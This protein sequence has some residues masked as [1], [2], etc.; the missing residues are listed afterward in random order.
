MP[1]K[2]APDPLRTDGVE[3]RFIGCFSS[4]GGPY[5]LG[6]AVCVADEGSDSPGVEDAI[7]IF[8]RRLR[9]LFAF[10]DFEGAGIE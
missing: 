1:E 8:T 5:V 7:K 2:V 6:C 4:Q 10:V 3:C 9:H